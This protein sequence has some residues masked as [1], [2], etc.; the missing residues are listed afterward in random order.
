MISNIWINTD[1]KLKYVQ[2]VTIITKITT[3]TIT[4][5]ITSTAKTTT[6]YNKSALFIFGVHYWRLG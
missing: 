4:I 5:I 3:R 1:K 6:R 2:R